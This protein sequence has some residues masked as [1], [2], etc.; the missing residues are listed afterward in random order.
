[1]IDLYFRPSD[2]VRDLSRNTVLFS[3][4]TL[5]FA[6]YQIPITSLPFLSLNL[7]P[8]EAAAVFQNVNV[9]S[10]LLIVALF[11]FA[12][13]CLLSSTEYLDWR[14]AKELAL[15]TSALKNEISAQPTGQPLSPTSQ[16]AFASAQKSLHVINSWNNAIG[17]TRILFEFIFPAILT[18]AGLWLAGG[19]LWAFIRVTLL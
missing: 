12:Q 10:V 1:M 11:H 17:V 5:F 9:T 18:I 6:I 16:E 13:L 8:Q 14:R 2:K 3:S 7:E 15:A 4:L 19:N